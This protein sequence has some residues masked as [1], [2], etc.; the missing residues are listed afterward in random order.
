MK[1]AA[2]AEQRAVPTVAGRRTERVRSLA[3]DEE[4]EGEVGARDSSEVPAGRE[5]ESDWAKASIAAWVDVGSTG[6]MV[7]PAMAVRTTRAD[8]RAL[9]SDL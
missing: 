5:E 6:H 7:Y 8:S 9:E 4:M 1:L 3:G 2:E